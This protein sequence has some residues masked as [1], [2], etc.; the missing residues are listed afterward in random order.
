MTTDFTLTD[1][2][3]YIIFIG[4]IY[5][6]IIIIPSQE[7]SKINLI[8]IVSII[9]IGFILLDCLNNNSES[10]SDT[11]GNIP[12]PFPITNLIAIPG[13][14]QATI[15]WTVPTNNDGPNRYNY[16]IKNNINSDILI[17]DA[18]TLI[19][20]LSQEIIWTSSKTVNGLTETITTTVPRLINGTTYTFTL[21]G[22]KMDGLMGSI[23]TSNSVTPS[24]TYNIKNIICLITFRPQE[25]WCKFLNQF[26]NY[27]IFIIVDD[28]NFNLSN[29]I[30][31][32]KN[33]TFIQIEDSKCKLNGFIDINFTLHKLITGWEKALYYFAVEYQYNNHKFI[34]FMED[35]VFFYNENTIIQIDQQYINDDLLSSNYRINND[36]NKNTW[37]WNRINIEYNPPYYEGMM[38]VVR[39]SNNM[40]KCILEYA[41]KNKTL[42]F[43]E[44]LFPTTAIKNNL[45]Y[46]TPIEFTNIHY[47]YNFEKKDIN[48]TNLYHPV[49]DLNNH[50]NFR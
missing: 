10:F 25:I 38:C 28:N 19:T 43:M 32:Y 29:F 26:K 2:I 37:H 4:I 6:L 39:F 16:I 46:N 17:V 50:I 47:R 12:E 1:L 41:K 20:Y 13:N 31:N 23:Y 9:Y 7:I 14:A 8:L 30:N 34:W 40:L 45:K 5:G 48:K 11:N 35:D 49:K 44:A 22:Q 15:N 36:G 3:K 27:N 33:I 21:H 42:Y 18:S 24:D